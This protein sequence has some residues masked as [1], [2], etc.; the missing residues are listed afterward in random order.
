[1]KTGATMRETRAQARQTRTQVRET[2]AP[3]RG[4]RRTILTGAALVFC[5]VHAAGP[6]E[7]AAQGG[8]LVVGAVEAGETRAPLSGAN[9]AVRAVADSSVAAG[10]LANAAGRFRVGGIPD[11]RYFVE[12]S[13]VGYATHRSQAFDMAGDTV[14]LG[15]LALEVSAVSLESIDV[16]TERAPATFAADRT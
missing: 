4:A 1:M 5:M 13:Y 10:S 12:V 11:G 8:G 14:D 7:A 16:R 15:T 3:I 2:R 6:A 9:V